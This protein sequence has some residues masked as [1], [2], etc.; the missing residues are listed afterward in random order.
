[1]TDSETQLCEA[2][3]EILQLTELVRGAFPF[4]PA[5]QLKDRMAIYIEFP[6]ESNGALTNEKS[7]S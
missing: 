2:E 4:V 5:G 6:P 1:M 7:E 3:D